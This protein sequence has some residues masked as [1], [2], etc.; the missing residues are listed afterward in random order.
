MTRT[1]CREQSRTRIRRI[2]G[3]VA[4]IARMIE[5]DRCCVDILLQVAAARAALDGLGKLLLCSHVETCVADAFAAGR[6]RER[7]EKVDELLTMLSRF[8]QVGGR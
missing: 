6:P 7:K 5:E 4:G 8:T 3:Q 2:G 1:D